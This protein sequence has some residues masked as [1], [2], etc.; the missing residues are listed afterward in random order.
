MLAVVR[1]NSIPARP[2]P[3]HDELVDSLSYEQA[4]LGLNEE[5]MGLAMSDMMATEPNAIWESMEVACS[6]LIYAKHLKNESFSIKEKNRFRKGLALLATWSRTS[7][8]TFEQKRTK[9]QE[10]LLNDAPEGLTEHDQA[11]LDETI[12]FMRRALS[13]PS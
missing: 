1:G 8:P 7:R 3:S 6:L 12:L 5:V 11:K 4:S 13:D 2:H 10:F 9:L